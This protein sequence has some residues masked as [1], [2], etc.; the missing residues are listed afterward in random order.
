MSREDI[1][2]VAARLFAIYLVVMTL[3]FVLSLVSIAGTA[4]GDPSP[5]LAAIG[6]S[7]AATLLPL[8][9]AAYL[10]FFPVTVARKLLPSMRDSGPSLPGSPR[11]LQEVAFSVLGL[12]LLASALPDVLYWAAMLNFRSDPAYGGLVLSADE[13]ASMVATGFE[14]VLGIAL[15]LGA[16]GLVG[17][18]YRLRYGNRTVEP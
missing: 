16:R 15:L 2:A 10:W 8:A 12:W 1:V 11:L 3:R 14:L 9:I 17:A 7:V 13:K 5:G 18:L 6:L 4:F